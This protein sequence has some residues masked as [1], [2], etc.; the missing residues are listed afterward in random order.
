[1]KE[2]DQLHSPAA[3]L[4]ELEWILKTR[5]ISLGLVRI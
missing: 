4:P 1:M 2:S 5:E 3:V